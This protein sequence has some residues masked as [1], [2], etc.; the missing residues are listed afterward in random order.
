[1]ANRRSAQANAALAVDRDAV[2]CARLTNAEAD[3]G[4]IEL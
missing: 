1:M 2:A 4:F 3:K